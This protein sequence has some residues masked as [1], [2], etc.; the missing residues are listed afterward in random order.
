MWDVPGPG[1]EPVPPA[2]AGR[3]LTTGPPERSPKL[4]KFYV[5]IN[6]KIYEGHLAFDIRKSLFN[7]KVDYQCYYFHCNYYSVLCF[8]RSIVYQI[9]RTSEKNSQRRIYKD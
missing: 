9:Q 4:P 2:L 6:V 7:F 5:S 3:F 8:S 1:L